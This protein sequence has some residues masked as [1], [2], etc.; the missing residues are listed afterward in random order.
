MDKTIQKNH[1]LHA[2]EISEAMRSLIQLG[3]DKSALAACAQREGIR[4]L[5]QDG[6]CNVMRGVT[7]LEE[8][9]RVTQEG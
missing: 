5:Y 2:L 1:E 6:L 7:T 9:L 3:S 4:T 8:V